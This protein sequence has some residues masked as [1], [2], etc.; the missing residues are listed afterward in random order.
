M[1]VF[2]VIICFLVFALIEYFTIPIYI[3]HNKDLF[4]SLYH[5][6]IIK[7]LSKNYERLVDDE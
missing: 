4:W 2:L 3:K 7:E 1:E 5:D 6:L